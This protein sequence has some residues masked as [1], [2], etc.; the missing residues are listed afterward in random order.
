MTIDNKH[1]EELLAWYVNGTLTSDERH[2]VESHLQSCTACQ[3]EVELLRT[4]QQHIRDEEIEGPGDFSRKRLMRDIKK[5]NTPSSTRR[6]WEPWA[7]AAAMLV[8]IIQ[9]AVIVNE[10]DAYNP[11]PAGNQTTDIKVKFVSNAQVN[12]ITRLLKSH[13]SVIVSGP[14]EDNYYFLDVRDLDV[15]KHRKKIE[16]IIIK[17]QKFNKIIEY[18][19]TE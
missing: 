19:D 8:I 17:L 16:A 15:K 2:H 5:E 12:K 6:W 1:P 10:P 13:N 18:A 9:A 3:R 11:I 7:A 4:L 14:D